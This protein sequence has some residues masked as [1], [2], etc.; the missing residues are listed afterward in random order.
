[1][2]KVGQEREGRGEVRAAQ[3]Q[4]AFLIQGPSLCLSRDLTQINTANANMGRAAG[5]SVVRQ[6]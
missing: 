4:H 5:P 2:E 3:L 1:M 6:A